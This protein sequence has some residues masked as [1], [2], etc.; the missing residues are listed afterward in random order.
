MNIRD[1]AAAAGVS[2]ATVSRV[3]N[4][5]SDPVRPETRQRVIEAIERLGYRPNDLAR[6]LLQRRTNVVGLVVPDIS[7]PYY[8]AVV[9]GVEDAAS[10][11]GY[12]VVLCNTDRDV[13]KMDAY[14]DTLVKSRA[15]GIVVAGG[16][17]GGGPEGQ[18]GRKG[19]AGTLSPQLFEPY[20]TKI[21]LVGRHDLPYPSVQIDNVGA[22]REATRHLTSLGH[23]RIAFIAG[24][25]V[26]H[27][28]Q[29]RLAGY[30]AALAEDGVP[31]EEGLVREGD[32]QEPSG[33]AATRALIED[34]QGPTGIVAANDRM[35]FGAMAALAD[36][37]LRVPEDV[38]LVGFDDVS[39]ASYLRPALTT[40]AVPSYRIGH[41]A[42]T[43]LLEDADPSA[44]ER[45]HVLPTEL[46]IRDTCGPPR[47]V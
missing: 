12:R 10:A 28:V 44:A 15:D 47:T 26:S 2:V 35:A 43:M 34:G 30:R 7:N 20:G 37:G 33:Y 22:A 9:R 11:A 19:A 46:V 18:G 6:A 21:V 41:T 42:M 8:P 5:T 31:A 45:P 39:I 32:F 29:D 25:L 36:L 17:M 24:P 27:T 14:L 16:G 1:V 38:S 4:P 23:R 3:L 40:V 13:E